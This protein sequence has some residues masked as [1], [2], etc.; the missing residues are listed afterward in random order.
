[1]TEGDG[2]KALRLAGYVGK[3]ASLNVMS[4]RI[5]GDER[6]RAAIK[7][8]CNKRIDGC[9]PELLAV[10]RKIMHDTSEKAADRLRAVSMVWDRA[11]PVM[12]RH[13]IE[14]EHHL[15]DDERDIQHY[16]GLQRLG[17]PREAFVARFGPNG[18]VRV[19]ALVAAEESKQR[20]IENGAGTIDAEYEDVTDEPVPRSLAPDEVAFDE[21]L[22]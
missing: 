10:V 16:R 11:N 8:A 7:E 1:V 6:V 9:E 17:A 19:E 21:D 20:Q 13:R 2:S 22:L 15:T 18:L 12:T 5:F 3:P 4:S 14:V